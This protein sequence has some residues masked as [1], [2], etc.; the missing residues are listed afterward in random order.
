MSKRILRIF[1]QCEADRRLNVSMVRSVDV[2]VS[3]RLQSAFAKQQVK[4]VIYIEIQQLRAD[5]LGYDSAGKRERI[6]QKLRAIITC[7]ASSPH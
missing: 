2:V 6:P 3:P 7:W 5:G 1:G 4:L